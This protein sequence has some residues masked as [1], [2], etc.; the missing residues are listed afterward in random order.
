MTPVAI[1]A[2]SYVIITLGQLDPMNAFLIFGILVGRQVVLTHQGY[3]GM[4]TGTQSGGIG[5]GR[6][7]NIA[8]LDRMSFLHCIGRGITAMAISTRYL[9]LGVDTPLR[10]N[11]DIGLILLV[12]C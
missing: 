7:A 1:E 12:E 11:D 8:G 2:S 9:T 6:Y 10:L 5:L 3:F 4:T